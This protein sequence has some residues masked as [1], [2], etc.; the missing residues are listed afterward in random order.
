VES[1]GARRE[2]LEALRVGGPTKRA[3][4]GRREV[5]VADFWMVEFE[6]I[7]RIGFGEYVVGGSIR[8]ATPRSYSFVYTTAEL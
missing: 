6:D 5:F 8:E 4:A 2:V 7:C 3:G 1:G